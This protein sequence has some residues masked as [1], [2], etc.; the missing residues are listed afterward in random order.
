MEPGQRPGPAHER[1]R[2]ETRASRK[3]WS[4]AERAVASR[5]AAVQGIE[6]HRTAQTVGVGKQRPAVGGHRPP[7][8]QREGRGLDRANVASSRVPR[9]ACLRQMEFPAERRGRNADGATAVSATMVPATTRSLRTE[10]ISALPS[11]AGRFHRWLGTV[12]TIRLGD[13]VSTPPA[14]R[15]VNHRQVV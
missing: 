4:E 9:P 5:G 10:R 6:D 8:D 2:P 15:S 14:V 7:W 3:L 12:K 13:C 11:R 1:A